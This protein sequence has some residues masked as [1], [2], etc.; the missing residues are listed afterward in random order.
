VRRESGTHTVASSVLLLVISFSASA[1]QTGAGHSPGKL[2]S[3]IAQTVE[4]VPFSF[5][6]GGKPSRELLSHWEQKRQ[7]ETLPG[8]RER[9][10]LT[11]RDRQT[12]LEIT[13]EVTLYKDFL[14][15]DWVVRLR[16]AG[17]TDTPII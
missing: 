14:A 16:N 6:Y 12:G 8:D 2:P 9:Q 5:V 10:V 13:D 3:V 15:V 4:T 7:T 11:Y 1:A 17:P